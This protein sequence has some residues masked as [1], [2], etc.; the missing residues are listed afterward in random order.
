M[1]GT[2]GRTEGRTSGNSPCVL[3]DIGPLGPLPKK[4]HKMDSLNYTM[5]N[6]TQNG[7]LGHIMAQNDGHGLEK[8]ISGR[9]NLLRPPLRAL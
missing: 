2:D 3:Q 6:P 4:G 1:G 7:H 8:H 5:K 9:K